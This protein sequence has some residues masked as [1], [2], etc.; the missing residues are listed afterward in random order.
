MGSLRRFL[1]RRLAGV[2]EL[3]FECFPLLL[4]LGWA[5][6][7]EVEQP[8]QYVEVPLCLAWLHVHDFTRLGAFDRVGSKVSVVPHRVDVIGEVG[9]KL[10]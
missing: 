9:G 2:L 4:G 5:D 6:K 7:I 10:F 8:L 1:Q 3:F